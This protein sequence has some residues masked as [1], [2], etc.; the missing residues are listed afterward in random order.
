MPV[1]T[2]IENIMIPW[3]IAHSLRNAAAFVFR[4]GGQAH[5]IAS[6]FQP[7]QSSNNEPRKMNLII[8]PFGGSAV[9]ML[10][11][12]DRRRVAGVN[13]RRPE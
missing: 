8:A 3:P 10:K 9:R 5:A 2:G 4:A 7:V 13:P 1:K 11:C 12:T 6:T